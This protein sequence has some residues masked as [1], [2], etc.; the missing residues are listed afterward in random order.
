MIEYSVV[1]KIVDTTNIYDDEGAL[2]K[3]PVYIEGWHVNMPVLV[4]ELI[5][6]QVFPP[7]PQ[8]VYSGAET[9]FYKFY[10]EDQWLILLDELSKPAEE[11]EE[12]V[13]E[14]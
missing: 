7:Y 9:F 2:L 13:D 10:S 6:F 11:P 3:E 8:R 12:V 14:E 1:G 4:P 5:S